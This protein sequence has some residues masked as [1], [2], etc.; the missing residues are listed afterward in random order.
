MPRALVAPVGF[1]VLMAY[2]CRGGLQPTN[3][4]PPA[5]QAPKA[6]TITNTPLKSS[7]CPLAQLVML[8]LLK[9]S[10]ENLLLIWPVVLSYLEGYMFQYSVEILDER[11]GPEAFNALH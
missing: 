3:S 11:R 5:T 4:R 9:Y 6:N 10:I 7:E 8:G 2:Q 1:C